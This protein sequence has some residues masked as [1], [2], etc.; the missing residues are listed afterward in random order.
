MHVQ[1]KPQSLF[2]PG[3]SEILREGVLW[4]LSQIQDNG[5]HLS[6]DAEMDTAI[7]SI[8]R[9]EG[10]KIEQKQT[11]QSDV[12]IGT[13]ESAEHL[14]LRKVGG[15][16]ELFPTWKSLTKFMMHPPRIAEIT[17]KTA[18][19]DIYVKVN[20]DGSGAHQISTGLGFFDHMLEQIARHGYIDLVINCKGDLHIDEHHT[21]E[22]TALALGD[23]LAKA[24]GD[25]RGIERYSSVLPMDETRA[26]VALDLSGRPY[27]VF[28]GIFS[29]EKVGDVPTELI[30][31]FFYSL[32][33]NLKATLHVEFQGEN[34]HHK[35]EACFKGFAK[36]LRD[37]VKRTRGNQIPSSK[38]VL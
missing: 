31:H 37:A 18:E 29:R 16:A 5:Y 1:L 9:N 25:K 2:R 33:M 26:M 15:E 12:I 14:M 10:I 32:A 20:L 24:V 4:S 17:R 27:L 13:D 30:K 8:L 35:I 38:G 19:T 3:S 21:I 22:D 6:I 28:D 11:V 7:L 34:D 36:V 23:A